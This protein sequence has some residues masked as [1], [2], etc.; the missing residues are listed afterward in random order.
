VLVELLQIFIY[1]ESLPSMVL[2]LV[3]PDLKQ[4]LNAVETT[5]PSLMDVEKLRALVSS[6]TIPG[7][8]LSS[9]RGILR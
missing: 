7:E 6:S 9:A 3:R 1:S 4:L 8:S 5:S 2:E